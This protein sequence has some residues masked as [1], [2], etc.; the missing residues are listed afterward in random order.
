MEK[1]GGKYIRPS[2]ESFPYR[3]Y[4]IDRY[5]LATKGIS[6]CLKLSAFVHLGLN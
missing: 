1:H 3:Q 5:D 4:K 6:L 2:G